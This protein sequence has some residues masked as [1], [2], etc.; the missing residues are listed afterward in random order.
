M[1]ANTL[2][3]CAQIGRLS[4]MRAPSAES[5]ARFAARQSGGRSFEQLTVAELLS[6][7]RSWKTRFVAAFARTGDFRTACSRAA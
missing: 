4:T 7:D 6:L 2:T 3:P 1:P 5:F